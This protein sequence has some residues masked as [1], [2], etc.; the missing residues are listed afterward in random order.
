MIDQDCGNKAYDSLWWT[1]DYRIHRSNG[2][3][4][5]DER[6]RRLS[7]PLPIPLHLADDGDCI[8]LSQ[9]PLRILVSMVVWSLRLYSTHL[10]PALLVKTDMPLH[11]KSNLIQLDRHCFLK[12]C[13]KWY[14]W[15]YKFDRYTLIGNDAPHWLSDAH[16]SMWAGVDLRLKPAWFFFKE[17]WFFFKWEIIFLYRKM[18]FSLFFSKEKLIYFSFEKNDFSLKRNGE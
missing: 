8:P 9:T 1:P 18:F 13:N 3:A 4:I 17:K 2:S 6:G 14:V 16:A 5:G 7:L 10:L 11:K 15:T 12:K